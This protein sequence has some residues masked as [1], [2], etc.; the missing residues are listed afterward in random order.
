MAKP[1]P[2]FIDHVPTGVLDVAVRQVMTPGVTTIA[3]NASLRQGFRALVAHQPRHT[4][5]GVLSP[6]ELM[7][8]LA[9]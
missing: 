1:D 7:A 2:K 4:P 9:R 5:E 3:E 6:L 8:L